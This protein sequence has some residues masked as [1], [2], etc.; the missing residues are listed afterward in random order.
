MFEERPSPIIADAQS[1]FKLPRLALL[2]ILAIFILPGVLSREFW[3]STE[4]SAFAVVLNMVNGSGIDWAL[5]NCQGS[6]E[7]FFAPLSLWVA[8][9][10]TELFGSWIPPE[11]AA[12]LSILFWFTLTTSAIW[13]GTW[14]L[15][16]RPEAQPVALAFGK[17]ANPKDYARVV[18]DGALLLF[19]AT[20]GLFIPLR[21]LSPSI[22]MI[23][24]SAG[25]TFSLIWSLAHPI[26]SSIA[27]GIL[28][29]C[30]VFAFDL[31]LGLAI[32]GISIMAQWRMHAIH[33][34]FAPRA[35]ATLIAASATF[36]IW[37]IAGIATSL[38]TI[39]AWFA[40]WFNHQ[41]SLLSG[42]NWHDAKWL[43]SNFIWFLWPIWPFTLVCL[44]C[45][46]KQLRRSHIQLPLWVL[47]SVLIWALL[48][49]SP[50]E[51]VFMA[52]LPPMTIL[53]SFGVM[54]NSRGWSAMLDWFSA[55]FFSLAILALWLYYFAWLGHFPP[56]M[57]ASVAR[58]APYLQP[59]FHGFWFAV[60][61]A[62]TL[63]WI[64]AM[65]WR[66][67]RLRH[68]AWKGPWLAA[69][70]MAALACITIHLFGPV[71]DA[72][73][74]YRTVAEAI[75]EDLP[76]GTLINGSALTPYE[77]RFMSYYGLPLTQASGTY[78]L[79]RDGN[80]QSTLSLHHNDNKPVDV[81]TRP[82]DRNSFILLKD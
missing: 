54:A 23:A 53:A 4:V 6:P 61:F 74:S 67:K 46:R 70:G 71:I 9:V 26:K 79:I 13:Y 34:P 7:Y 20:F 62:A 65:L 50:K 57:Y 39:D 27:T 21:E 72:N 14:Y 15:A 8:A 5:P 2:F 48:V 64:A 17:S 68:A 38:E 36:F 69:A 76:P 24:I 43:L 73:R 44:R 81:Y 60:A 82:G 47:T 51:S 52:V 33:D 63:A 49:E 30:A 45:Y 78:R 25:F 28:S 11:S 35:L 37:P 32:L 58:L 19:V 3:G 22:A 56:K 55:T 10:F 80:S 41:L 77:Y 12:R 31:W 18:A 59:H 40:G 29:A 1:A 42:P 16:R 66:S 75:L